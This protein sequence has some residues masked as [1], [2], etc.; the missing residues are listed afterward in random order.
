MRILANHANILLL[1]LL[2]NSYRWNYTSL[3]SI[4]FIVIFLNFMKEWCSML[5]AL[6]II[7]KYY[8]EFEYGFV[9]HS[10]MFV[11]AI[12]MGLRDTFFVSKNFIRGPPYQSK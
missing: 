12:C 5:V 7:L 2:W 8:I 9:F 3:K 4:S 1:L 10:V 6:K 11:Y